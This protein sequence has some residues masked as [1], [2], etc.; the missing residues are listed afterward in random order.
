MEETDI[1]TISIEDF[2]AN[3]HLLDY[4]EHDVIVVKNE[5]FSGKIT[6]D[7]RLSD[8]FL[9]VYCFEGE[10]ELAP[11]ES[12]RSLFHSSMPSPVF[13]FVATPTA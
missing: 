1:K 10:A 12:K 6:E 2:K 3:K 8:C 7:I 5:N 13:S 4:C 9:I 11:A